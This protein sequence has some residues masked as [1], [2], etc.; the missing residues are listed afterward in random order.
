MKRLRVTYG[1]PCGDMD[2]E[3]GGDAKGGKSERNLASCLLKKN[4]TTTI[5]IQ[6]TVKLMAGK[7]HQT[8]PTDNSG[9]MEVAPTT[10]TRTTSISVHLITLLPAPAFQVPGLRE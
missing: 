10:T 2:G 5:N 9:I 4:V 6:H 7:Q 1:W 3:D 8:A